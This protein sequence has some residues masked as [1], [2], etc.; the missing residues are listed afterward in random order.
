MRVRH[1][2]LVRVTALDIGPVDLHRSCDALTF[3]HQRDIGF[4]LGHAEVDASVAGA[5]CSC[6]GDLLTGGAQKFQAL[7]LHRPLVV[8]GL[9]DPNVVCVSRLVAERESLWAL[10]IRELYG[11]DLVVL[12]DAPVRVDLQ[13][14]GLQ[15]GEVLLLVVDPERRQTL[16]SVLVKV[17]L[18]RQ[19]HAVH[20]RVGDLDR[21]ICPIGREGGL[22]LALARHEV[23]QF[24]PV[25][26]VA[27]LRRCF[28]D[29]NEGTQRHCRRKREL[30][31]RRHR[32]HTAA[33]P[34][35][36]LY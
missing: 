9:H 23:L 16:S 6:G 20:L 18:H 28:A 1:L 17:Q 2:D 5:E 14:D 24:H 13:L 7:Q 36:E 29:E 3:R 22:E 35:A 10:R 31:R 11:P 26:G 32:A 34:T 19:H 21:E 27:W 4:L 25:V 15:W 30:E 8:G 33:R 12:P